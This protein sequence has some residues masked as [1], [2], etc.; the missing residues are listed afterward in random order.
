MGTTGLAAGRCRPAMGLASVR[1]FGGLVAFALCL[2]VVVWLI[3]MLSPPR[4]AGVVLVGADYAA[5]LAVPHNVLGYQGLKGIEQLVKAPKPWSLFN[6]HLQLIPN[7]RGQTILET[8][9]SWDELITS[10]KKGFS[11]PNL[12]L[13]LALHGGS[14]SGGAYL[15]PNR[16]KRP[17]DRLEMKKVIDSMKELPAGKVEALVVEG[18]QVDSDWR[19]G[20]LHNDF[21]RRLKELEPQI[22]D[23]PNL[24]VLSGCDVDQRCW[25][26]EGLGQT[27]F[28]HYVTEALRSE[29][30]SGHDN[31]LSLDELHRY[32]RDNVKRWALAA[33]GAVQQPVLLPALAGG[34]APPSG[35]RRDPST[36]HLATVETATTSA[37]PAPPDRDALSSAW[38]GYR[39]LDA[40][41]PH[42]SVYSPMRWRAYGATLVRYEQ[43]LLAGA[44]DAAQPVGEQLSQ[45][46]QA[47]RKEQALRGLGS[48]ADVNLVMDELN[49][50][51]AGVPSD[52]AAFLKIAVADNQEAQRLWDALRAGE[53]VSEDSRGTVRPLRLRLAEYLLGWAQDDRVEDLVRAADH[54]RLTGL[55]G[56]PLPAEAHFLRM[57]RTKLS[58][59]LEVRPRPFWRLASQALRVRTLAER[60]AMGVSP[61]ADGYP[62]SEQVHAWTRRT[63]E[64]A[65]NNRRTGEDQLFAADEPTWELARK[66]LE[67]AEGDYNKA[68]RQA[69]EVRSAL[70]A[71]DRALAILPGYSRWVVHRH[72]EDPKDD[73]AVRVETLWVKA[74]QLS[75]MLKPTDESTAPTAIKQSAQDLETGLDKLV[76]QFVQERG[77]IARDRQREDWEVDSS[78][79][80]VLFPDDEKLTI[81]KGIWDRLDDIRR[82][83]LVVAGSSGPAPQTAESS[84]PQPTTEP[85]R[86]A[87]TQGT[88]A[89]AA[90][91]ESWFSDPDFK[92]LDEGDY[93]KTLEGLRALPA[94]TADANPWWNEAAR[95]GDRIGQRFRAC[96]ARSMPCRTR[97]AGS[98]NWRRSPRS[99]PGCPGPTAWPAWTTAAKNRRPPRP[100]SLLHDIARRESTTF[101]S[102][103]LAAPRAI[104]GTARTPTPPRPTSGRSLH[105]CST[106]PSDCSRSS[107]RPIRSAAS[108]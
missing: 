98:R 81:R 42:P 43:L 103:W 34:S 75:E 48:S 78:A 92:D 90:L 60:A 20:M 31:R 52:A 84:D 13:V 19:L 38:L 62:Y 35:P 59:A 26:S 79:A 49:G 7:P 39:R 51:A 74:H 18:A 30:A 6:Y 15:M 100:S 55:A 106:T 91:G 82:H 70:G 102:G 96:V 23:V 67:A 57:L 25:A 54:I 21:A 40:L 87:A 11:E 107:R 72:S 12:I 27:V 37:A 36:V 28:L 61:R 14:D 66:D 47:I 4:P 64:Q 5:N 1:L 89:L 45:L 44:S 32:V 3:W 71:R 63:I 99:S 41:V 76:E 22:R 85:A 94:Q 77:T 56:E 46:E 95:Q 88:L 8:A 68:L 65:D 69:V 97:D 10:L 16:M 2:G 29:S 58:P 53:T 9:D 108:S 80:A 101:S 86:R 17:E 50:G 105:G 24:W 104:T 73:L 33:R 83:D 93:R